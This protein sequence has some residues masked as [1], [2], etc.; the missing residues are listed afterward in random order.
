MRP[1]GQFDVKATDDHGREYV[2]AQEIAQCADTDIYEGIA[3]IMNT[4]RKACKAMLEFNKLYAA[5]TVG[6]PEPEVYSDFYHG[7][8]F[9]QHTKFRDGIPNGVLRVPIAIEADEA[10]VS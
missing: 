2:V 6:M 4:C 5:G 1:L 8:N 3:L 7:S 10:Y 9:M